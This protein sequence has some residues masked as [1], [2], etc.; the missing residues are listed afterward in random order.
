MNAIAYNWKIIMSWEEKQI[1]SSEEVNTINDEIDDN[2]FLSS[3]NKS[4]II[5]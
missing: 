4:S 2:M 3:I 5:N 1:S